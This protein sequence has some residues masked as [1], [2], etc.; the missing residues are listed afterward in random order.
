MIEPIRK[1]E[2]GG[3]IFEFKWDF[4]N[5]VLTNERSNEVTL[6]TPSSFKNRSHMCSFT[7]KGQR[8]MLGK[9][10]QA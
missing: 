3:K 8:Y 2:E 9:C 7:L 10:P 5:G 4:N 6:N 1:G